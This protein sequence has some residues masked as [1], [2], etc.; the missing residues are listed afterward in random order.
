MRAESGCLPSLAGV[1]LLVLGLT[2]CGAGSG[3]A[4]VYE[5]YGPA[6]EG[7]Y[8]I[9]RGDTLVKIARRHKVGADTLARW[10]K[11]GPPYRIYAG[12]LLR[13]DPP[14]GK[15][16]RSVSRR[17]KTAES[18]TKTISM[19]RAGSDTPGGASKRRES[20]GAKVTSGL[21]WRWPLDGKVVQRFRSGDRTRQGIRIA[22]RDGQQ[23]RAAESGT[24]V[25][26][27]SGLKGYGNLIIVKHNDSYLSAY[28]F[29]R[30]LL[31]NEG[32]QV[33]RGQAVAEVGQ[34]ASGKYRLHFEIR[35]EGTAVD[36]LK[37]LP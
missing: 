3:P 24:V 34:A 29:N 27:G 7:Y 14:G 18:A 32:A 21:R 35:R 26:S 22:G 2:G 33:K 9:R 37:Y 12:K 28:G 30:R 20:V 10:N 1:F 16:G 6:P 31:V 8:R 11:L 25:Y 13:V 15:R 36:P 23:V 17:S 5:G 4:P 19:N